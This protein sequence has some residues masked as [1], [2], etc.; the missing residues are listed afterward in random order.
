LMPRAEVLR[1]AEKFRTNPEQ[2]VAVLADRFGVSQIAMRRRLYE[3]GILRRGSRGIH[4]RA[5]RP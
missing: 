4:L 1:E 5:P 2:L 3:L